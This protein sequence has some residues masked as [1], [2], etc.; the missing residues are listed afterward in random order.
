MHFLIGK[1]KRNMQ[2]ITIYIILSDIRK[3][4]KIDYF[5]DFFAIEHMRIRSIKQ[6]YLVLPNGWHWDMS[7]YQDD[8]FPKPYKERFL[9]NY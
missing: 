3:S 2:M 4:K 6:Y 1:H 5:A 9:V 8:V 7:N